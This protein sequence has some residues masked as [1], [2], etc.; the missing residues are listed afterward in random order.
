MAS[1]IQGYDEERF[2]T[3]IN[4]NFLCLICFNVLKEPVLC[5]RNQHCFCRG[6]ITKHLE[7]SRRCPTCA[8]E[9]TEETLTEP[10]RMVKDYLNESK[11]RCVYHDRGCEE[12]VQLQHLDQH[13]D[14]C[15]FTPAVCT[16]PGCGTGLN[17]RDL[18]IHESELCEY[19]KLK[20]HSCGEM[21]KTL[22][23]MNKR[24]ETNQ[25]NVKT[26]FV[27]LE[28]NMNTR[29]D[30]LENNNEIRTRNTDT[31][32]NNNTAI[33][34]T[35]MANINTRMANMETKMDQMKTDIEG[36]FETV[37]NEV[38]GLKT[39]LVEAFDQMKDVLIKMEDNIKENAKKIRYAPSGDRQ[40]I[41]VAGGH[42]KD[43]V[44]MFNWRQRTW[45]PLQSMPKKR[46]GAIS[47]V[48]KNQI[49]IAGGYCDGYGYLDDIIRMNVDLHPDLSI[50]WSDCPVKLPSKMAHHSSVLYDNKVIV[51]GG[52]DNNATSD[53]IHE[54]QVVP[55]YTVKSLSRM[56]EP[57]QRQCT[58]KFHDSLLILGGRRTTGNYKH[59]LSSVVLYDIKNNV[60]KQ[61]APLPYEVSD[62]ATVRWGDN[63]V[64]IGG[65]DKIGNALNT[66]IMY[67]VKTEQSHMLPPMRC[68][69]WGCAAV[70]VGNNIVALGGYTTGGQGELKSVESFNFERNTW[71]ELPE[72]FQTRRWH[73]A[74]V[75]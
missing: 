35:R 1:F 43:S 48:Y 34:D 20:C 33:M 14:S 53:K 58:E 71:E 62:M 74:V 22:A 68:K 13:E 38:K 12:I 24:M 52:R 64:V 21:T 16:N 36:K 23:D 73:T 4:R 19:R 45:S 61:L 54:V 10:S 18:A 49:I 3:T 15:G 29:L 26:K 7:N 59:N 47:F 60:C 11:I 51:T 37:N 72:M 27:N 17:K 31:T 9:L 32:M 67:N 57:R 2:V 46:Y 42:G 70:V 44:E 30:N 6:C 56:P 63:V 50:H 65:I 66:V 40:N 28:K 39:A 8:D 25:A 41:I 55:P 69:R 75:V 5:P